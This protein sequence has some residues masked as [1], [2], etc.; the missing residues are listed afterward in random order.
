MKVIIAGS[1]D[2]EDPDFV[3]QAV[4]K[5]G[6]NVTEVV[7]GKARGVDF[8]GELWANVNHVPIKGFPADW[9]TYGKSAGPIRNR[10]MAEYADVLI[11]VWDGKSKGTKDMIKQMKSLDKPCFVVIVE[12][13]P[14]C[15]P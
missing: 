6:Y 13:D 14:V 9:D 3:Y 8:L 15:H 11:A 7:S 5:S 2:I 1:R 4:E 12:K 10:Q